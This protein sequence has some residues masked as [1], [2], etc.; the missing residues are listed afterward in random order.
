MYHE[1]LKDVAGIHNIIGDE[2][3]K[4]KT[5]FRLCILVVNVTSRIHNQRRLRITENG[6]SIMHNQRYSRGLELSGTMA[7][8]RHPFFS[9]TS[10]KRARNTLKVAGSIL[11]ESD[12]GM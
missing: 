4:S 2:Y 10:V 1:E 3:A 9:D 8:K 11:G 7:I 5:H 12:L 6:V